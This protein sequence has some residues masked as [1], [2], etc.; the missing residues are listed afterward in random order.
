MNARNLVVN[1]GS[2][3][4]AM[5]DPYQRMLY[6]RMLS[7]L[8]LN[9]KTPIDYDVAEILRKEIAKF[10]PG[11]NMGL[12]VDLAL[13]T[14]ACHYGDEPGFPH[15]D[16]IIP[17]PTEEYLKIAGFEIITAADG[18]QYV[19]EP[20]ALGWMRETG[21]WSVPVDDANDIQFKDIWLYDV[22]LVVE[23]TDPAN[24]GIAALYT[25]RVRQWQEEI[26]KYRGYSADGRSRR[27]P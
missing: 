25:L 2:P 17:L 20:G 12:G 11:D 26:R 5:R 16:P 15:A 21:R 22:P 24:D 27:Q 10:G 19:L 6:Q 9:P 23:A 14:E 8:P 18:Q 4:C 13:A 7:G 3:Q 1:S